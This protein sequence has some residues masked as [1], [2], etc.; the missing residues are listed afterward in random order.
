MFVTD[1]LIYLQLQKTACSHIAAM[2][3]KT[4]GGKKEVEIK[5]KL[6]GLIHLKNKFVPLWTTTLPT[7]AMKQSICPPICRHSSTA[8]CS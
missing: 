2:L 7:P 5:D 6:S 1:K 4:V 3:E 8:V